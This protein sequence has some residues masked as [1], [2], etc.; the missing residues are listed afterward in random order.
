ML[1]LTLSI[2]LTEDDQ[3]ISTSQPLLSPTS[4]F[5]IPEYIDNCFMLTDLVS[6]P[7]YSALQLSQDSNS[8]ISHLRHLT[9]CFLANQVISLNRVAAHQIEAVCNCVYISL[10]FVLVCDAVNRDN[11]N[12]SSR[13]GYFIYFIIP[14]LQF[15]VPQPE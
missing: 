4:P 11:H 9:N 5:R 7:W 14:P 10:P 1:N 3:F 12:G 2:A 8:C 15:F 13:A 6:T